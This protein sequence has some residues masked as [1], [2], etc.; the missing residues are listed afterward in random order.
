MLIL[1]LIKSLLL[2]KQTA[3]KKSMSRIM[4]IEQRL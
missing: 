3:N 1:L 2:L 4:E